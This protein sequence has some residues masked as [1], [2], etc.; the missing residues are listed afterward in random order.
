M[1][2]TYVETPST[3]WWHLH[4]LIDEANAKAK[5]DTKMPHRHKNRE[6]AGDMPKSPK[7][8]TS[9]Q[10]FEDTLQSPRA[11]QLREREGLSKA[12]FRK[13]VSGELKERGL[14][15]SDVRSLSADDLDIVLSCAATK[16]A[17]KKRLAAIETRGIESPEGIA[18]RD[19]EPL[20]R[21]LGEKTTAQLAV[22]VEE[23]TSS[24]WRPRVNAAR[25]FAKAVTSGEAVYKIS[26]TSKKNFL[27]PA[28]GI[29]TLNPKDMPPCT[30]IHE[31]LHARDF[32]TSDA[33]G[34][35]GKP[36]GFYG[37]TSRYFDAGDGLIED[38]LDKDYARIVQKAAGAGVTVGQYVSSVARNHGLGKSYEDIAFLSDMHEAASKGANDIGY[39]HTGEDPN[40][41]TSPRRNNRAN[42]AAANY[43]GCA[44][45]NMLEFA[46]MRFLFPNAAKSLDSLLE[47]MANGG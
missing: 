21:Q 4:S 9:G 33:D 25:A 41:W 20:K 34:A 44:V 14:K 13:A 36:S 3:S 16:N 31:A 30:I 10:R 22:C 12:E 37:F 35:Y 42:E 7:V 40:Y 11:K 39:G 45:T 29:I 28:S 6:W 18:I 26:P 2:E 8:K 38:M 32:N 46:A 23:A 17:N 24:G 27:N 19:S 43:G 5:P 15:P 1:P 47:V